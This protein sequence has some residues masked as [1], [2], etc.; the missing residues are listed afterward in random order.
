MAQ[1]YFQK[2]LDPRWQKKRLSILEDAE[3]KCEQCLSSENTLHVHHKSYITGLEPWEYERF[4]LVVLCSECHSTAHENEIW[5]QEVI[6]HFPIDGPFN[7]IEIA[8]LLAGV[9]G[10]PLT[11]NKLH[12]RHCD[13]YTLG[14]RVRELLQ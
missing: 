3:W 6:T 10:Y 9:A 12:V 8:Y 2:L 5:L 4:Q 14:L 13:V 7:R 11:T 1:T